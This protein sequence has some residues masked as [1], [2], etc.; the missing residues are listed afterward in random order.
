MPC[1]PGAVWP[2]AAAS[3]PVLQQNW[4]T[5]GPTHPS[6]P[7]HPDYLA[8]RQLPPVRCDCSCTCARHPTA[9]ASLNT[10]RLQS[11]PPALAS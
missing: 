4:Y 1:N 11:A 8:R 3:T 2:C 6:Q 7:A 10:G 5:C 9:A